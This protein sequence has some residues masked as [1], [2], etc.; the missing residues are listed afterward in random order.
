MYARLGVTLPPALLRLLRAAT[1]TRHHK[2]HYRKLTMERKI[3]PPLLPGFELAIFP[4]RVRRFTNWPPN[5]GRLSNLPVYLPT[6]QSIHLPAS[7][8][9]VSKKKKKIG[10]KSSLSTWTAEQSANPS[11]LSCSGYVVPLNRFPPSEHLIHP[12]QIIQTVISC[13]LQ[14]KFPLLFPSSFSSDTKRIEKK[15]LCLRSYFP[16]NHTGGFIRAQATL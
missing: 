3:L 15:S 13:F 11:S 5:S 10:S 7:H 1:V 6:K 8:I 4:S 9:T 2:S 14:Y 16:P 12:L